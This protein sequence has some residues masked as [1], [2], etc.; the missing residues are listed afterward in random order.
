MK[1]CKMKR[2]NLNLFHMVQPEFIAQTGDP[3]GIG[4]GGDS[5]YG[6]IYGHQAR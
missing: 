6:E 2:Y 5:I 3:D 1:L 4:K